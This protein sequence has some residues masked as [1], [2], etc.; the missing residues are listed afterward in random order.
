MDIVR[1]YDLCPVA[2]GHAA[3]VGGQETDFLEEG[4]IYGDLGQEG[5]GSF[6]N[7]RN[8]KIKDIE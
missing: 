1:V 2:L 3:G 6:C 7:L 8:T 5:P 4:V